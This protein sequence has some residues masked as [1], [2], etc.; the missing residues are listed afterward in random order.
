MPWLQVW[1]CSH[2]SIDYVYLL[3]HLSLSSAICTTTK[4]VCVCF[5]PTSSTAWAKETRTNASVVATPWSIFSLFHHNSRLYTVIY[6]INN[7]SAT[8][9]LVCLYTAYNVSKYSAKTLRVRIY[10]DS[11]S[12]YMYNYERQVTAGKKNRGWHST[13][14]SMELRC[15]FGRS[16]RA[17][18]RL[19]HLFTASSYVQ[20]QCSTAVRTVVRATQ[21][22]NGKWPFSGCQNSVTPEPID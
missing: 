3:A 15:P 14:P 6:N 19:V 4:C 2:L 8:I 9:C 5:A 1:L 12:R 22:V 10:V 21:Q 16:T 11:C 17:T 18:L 13:T 20:S 7:N